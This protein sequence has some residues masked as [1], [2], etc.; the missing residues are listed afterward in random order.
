MQKGFPKR[1]SLFPS[2]EPDHEA[3]DEECQRD[4]E[5]DDG[6]PEGN[7]R[8]GDGEG[9]HLHL[10]CDDGEVCLVRAHP[11]DGGDEQV[12]VAAGDVHDGTFGWNET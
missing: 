7:V 11:V 8:F 9:F 5:D 10:L 6:C 2:P 12:G 4:D 3:P 1:T